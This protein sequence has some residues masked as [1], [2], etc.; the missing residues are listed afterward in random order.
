MGII[1]NNT[2]QTGGSLILLICDRDIAQFGSASALG[3]EC[4]RFK[5]CYPETKVS[6]SMI[7]Q[8]G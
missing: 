1:K 8:G 6:K 2:R 7:D 4:H 3:A 5:S